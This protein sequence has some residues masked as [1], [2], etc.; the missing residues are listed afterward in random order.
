M[1]NLIALPLMILGVFLQNQLHAQQRF[2]AQL[3]SPISSSSELVVKLTNHKNDLIWERSYQ[4]ELFSQAEL[5]FVTNGKQSTTIGLNTTDGACL[6]TID[7]KGAILGLNKLESPDSSSTITLKDG[8]VSS[9][10]QQVVFVG[11]VG[12]WIHHKTMIGAISEY[13]EILWCK[14]NGVSCSK[15]QKSAQKVWELPTRNSEFIVLES[16]LH[17]SYRW[18]ASGFN[19]ASLLHVKNSEVVSRRSI[20]LKLCSML[21]NLRSTT[22]SDE[23]LTDSLSQGTGGWF[24]QESMELNEQGSVFKLCEGQPIS[25]FER[26]MEAQTI[27]QATMDRDG[28]PSVSSHINFSRVDLEE[29]A[30]QPRT[31]SQ[32]KNVVFWKVDLY[33]RPATDHINIRSNQKIECWK[34][35]SSTGLVLMEG[36]SSL[37]TF[38]TVNFPAGYYI[39]ELRSGGTMKL[40][41]FIQL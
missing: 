29:I 3:I 12:K 15:Y 17:N 37:K 13:G 38:S 30:S 33:P 35:L 36:S 9:H 5:A 6:V 14:S 31:V 25:D 26:N 21:L 18:Q 20:D 2:Q 24:T 11:D 10:N 4:H 1:K 22:S 19:E 7:K 34:V 27:L 41:R 40:E 28:A 8:T 32:E 23:N 16:K 39:L